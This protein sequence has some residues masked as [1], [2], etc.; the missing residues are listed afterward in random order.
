[1]P[2]WDWAPTAS[3]AMDTRRPV[4]TLVGKTK[5][6]REGLP[7]V[8][9]ICTSQQHANGSYVRRPSLSFGTGGRRFRGAFLALNSGSESAT[10]GTALIRHCLFYP[11]ASLDISGQ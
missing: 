9:N 6:A 2:G 3:R 8:D 4:L 11:L 5:T 7:E 10:L 1:M